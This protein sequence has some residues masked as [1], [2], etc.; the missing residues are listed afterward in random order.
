METEKVCVNL[1]AAELGKLDVLVAEGIYVSRTDAVRA[2]LRREFDAQG[3]AI[4]RHIAATGAE[5]L[6]LAPAERGYTVIQGFTGIGAA[7][8]T[9]AYLEDLRSRGDRANIVC[10]GI[11][12]FSQD[13][14]AELADATIHRIRLLG[15]LRGPKDV[16][17]AISDRVHRGP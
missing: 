13:V 4:E 8:L 5:G 10:A 12:T 16:L 9:A 15:A 6:D 11:V 14:T 3:P 2:A 17:D 7:F 1:S